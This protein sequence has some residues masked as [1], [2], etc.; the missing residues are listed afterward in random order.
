VKFNIGTEN[1]L[2]LANKNHSLQV[3]TQLLLQPAPEGLNN[4]VMDALDESA[5]RIDFWINLR[6]K[7]MTEQKDNQCRMQIIQHGQTEEH[8]EWH[9]ASQFRTPC[10]SSFESGYLA[11]YVSVRVG[12]E[13]RAYRP[14]SR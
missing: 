11:E 6:C 13:I 2:I 7:C 3:E 8:P 9:I 5:D 10:P 4:G 14:Q 1:S 12:L